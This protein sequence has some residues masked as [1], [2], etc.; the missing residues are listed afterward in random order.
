[1]RKNKSLTVRIPL[2]DWRKALAAFESFQKKSRF[3]EQMSDNAMI[4]N[5]VKMGTDH[6]LELIKDI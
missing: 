4:R 5:L 6:L 2:E 3:S 1:M